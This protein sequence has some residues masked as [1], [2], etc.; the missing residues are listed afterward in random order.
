[1]VLKD[2]FIIIRGAGEMA[3]GVATSLY[4][5]NM[6]NILMLEVPSPL[7]VRRRV[8]FCE[9]VNQNSMRVEGIEAILINDKSAINNFLGRGQIPVIVDT[10]GESIASL[11]PDILID[12]TL[13]K[14]N[15]GIT[16]NDAPLVIALGPGFTAGRD[17]HL[18]VETNRGHNLGQI[19][20]SGEAEADTGIPG[21]IEGY[22]LE[23]VVRA[24]EKGIFISEMQIGNLV[25]KGDTIG[26]I[27]NSKVTAPISGM[28]RCLIRPG[29]VVTTGLKIGD[30][31]P[32]GSRSSCETI[33]EK[34]R[35][36]GRAVLEGIMSAYNV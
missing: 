36:I 3:T 34:A 19:I 13:A 29:S 28:L 8:S 14:K 11:K 9:A 1:M 7:A 18:V 32:R 16:I 26:H 27:G 30:I 35:A 2:R 12:A 21:D 6:R 22:T 15:L 31:D 24:P 33:S 5:A 25:S 17:C 23:R 20:F 10:G 4:R